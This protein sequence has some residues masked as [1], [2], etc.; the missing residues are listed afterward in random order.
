MVQLLAV[1]DAGDVAGAGHGASASASAG[2]ATSLHVS[3][4][5]SGTGTLWELDLN[6]ADFES[7]VRL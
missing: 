4:Y 7:H 1:S 3:C 5:S 2:V 6:E